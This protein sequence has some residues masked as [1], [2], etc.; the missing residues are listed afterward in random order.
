MSGRPEHV[1]NRL[2]CAFV[3]ALVSC[4]ADHDVALPRAE[5]I[6]LTQGASGHADQEVIPPGWKT[7]NAK[8]FEFMVPPGMEHDTKAIAIDSFARAYESESIEL[9][10]DYGRYSDD[11][12]LTYAHDVSGVVRS[13]RVVGGHQGTLVSYVS[14]GSTYIMAIHFAELGQSQYGP[15][16]LTVHARSKLESDVEV[17]RKILGSIKF[18]K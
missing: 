5:G 12:D 7:I 15:I 10:F 6:S 14:G 8:Y 16:K 11:F 17:I 13:A 9:G 3:L 1:K 4:N 18:L 2:N